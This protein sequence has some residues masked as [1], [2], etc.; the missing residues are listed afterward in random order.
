MFQPEAVADAIYKAAHEHKREYWLGRSSVGIILANFI[1]PELLDRYLARSAFKGQST[2]R[3][4]PADRRDNLVRPVHELHRTRGSFGREAEARAYAL[5]GPATRVA[6]AA[7][8]V[9]AAG[10]IGMAIGRMTSR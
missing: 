6:A 3:K 8:S 5:P 2:R 1:A 9:L 10:L 7:A 4:V